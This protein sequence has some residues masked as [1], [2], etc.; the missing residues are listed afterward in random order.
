MD[1]DNQLDPAAI[2]DVGTAKL[3]LRWAIEKIHTLSDEGARLK[4]DNRNK[5]A[6]NRMLIQQNEQKD[7]ILKK[8][9]S[10][11]KTWE[12]NWKT[13]TAMEADLKGKLREQILNEETASWRQ[14]KA[15]MENEIKA[16]KT[17][18]CSREAEIGRMKLYAID[19]IRKANELKDAETQAIILSSQDSLAERENAVR[20]KFERFEKEFIETQ[21]VKIEQDELALTARHETKMREFSR[22]YQAKEA[23]LEEFRKNLEDD[24][25]KKS[26]ALAAERAAKLQETRLE[27]AAKSEAASANADKDAARR[28]KGIEAEFDKKRADMRAEFEERER[29]LLADKNIE[30]SA[31]RETDQKE[32]AELRGRLRQYILEREQDYVDM[33]LNMEAQLVELVKKH[34]EASAAA[35]QEASKATKEQWSRLAIENQKKLD[36]MIGENNARW[37]TDWSRREA[38]LAAQREASLSA[39]KERL[40]ADFRIKEEALRKGLLN[41]QNKSAAAQASELEKAKLD[42]EKAHE[43]KLE[44]VKASLI[45]AYSAKERALDERLA[46]AENR[47]RN[48]WVVKEE[49]WAIEKDHALLVEKDKLKEDFAKRIEDKMRERTAEMEKQF[50]A[51]LHAE[52][53]RLAADFELKKKE[54]AEE[55]R[56]NLADRERAM[57]EKLDRK[58]LELLK[59]HES[60]M[61]RLAEEAS[62][63]ERATAQKEAALAAKEEEMRADYLNQLRAEKL[64]IADSYKSREQNLQAREDEVQN[65]K[66]SL[67]QQHSELKIKL[68]QEIQQKESEMFDRMAKAKEEMFRSMNE[69]RSMLEKEYEDR[70]NA[71]RE[72]EASLQGEFDKKTAEWLKSFNKPQKG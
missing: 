14:A 54:L 28:V 49:E 3:A 31:L 66:N 37:E 64:K 45:R 43:E 57:G 13:Q 27:L 47:M 5:V 63:L 68:Y 38:E 33:R 71:L 15:Q 70:M 53:Q 25:L 16:I 29:A 26:E 4:E 12:E 22:L 46:A 59:N 11:I 72:K 2:T 60:R 41:E 61:A 17:E 18:L 6:S 36:A 48:E 62:S 67:L 44:L 42:L 55:L 23:Q 52:K 35:F 20:A 69:R 56:Q 51:R 24:Y 7:E 34:D 40:A 8:W 50:P 1:F 39:D 58:G 21:R 32:L 9:Q 30:I 10:T 19:E 65:L